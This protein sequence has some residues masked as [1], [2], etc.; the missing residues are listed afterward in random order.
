MKK[1]LIRSLYAGIGGTIAICILLLGSG[2]FKHPMIM[3][4]F[5]AS[6]VILF[7]LPEAP[8]AQPRNVIGGHFLSTL[9][10][11]VAAHFLPANIAVISVATGL[12][13]SI[14]VIT[15]TTHPPAGAD[16]L[17][18]LLSHS[19]IPWSFL[20]FPVVAGSVVLVFIATVYHPFTTKAYSHVYM[21]NFL[22]NKGNA[23]C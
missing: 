10:G 22:K 18:V 4:P 16:P 8:L 21:P 20:L 11:L 19:V 3:A 23:L 13:I 12:A 17:V 5:G 6:C 7:A 1:T 2:L 9:T 15:K 14:M